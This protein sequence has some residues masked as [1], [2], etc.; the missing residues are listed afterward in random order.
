MSSDGAVFLDGF[1]QGTFFAVVNL[2][3]TIEN[4]R[5]GNSIYSGGRTGLLSPRRVAAASVG[6]HKLAVSASLPSFLAPLLSPSLPVLLGSSSFS[7]AAAAGGEN[8]LGMRK[9]FSLRSSHKS[10]G[11]SKI[12]E[13]G[14]ARCPPSERT[15]TAVQRY[16]VE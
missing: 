14:P 9:R 6:L 3:L 5:A 1:R 13:N 12:A 4:R 8:S 16:S 15:D 2:Q 7:G 11:V 10:N